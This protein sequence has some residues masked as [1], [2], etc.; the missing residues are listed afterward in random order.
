MVLQ[1]TLRDMIQRKRMVYYLTI[2]VA[3]VT[4]GYGKRVRGFC[5]C[6]QEP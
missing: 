3:R 5:T 4:A 2:T 1:I 6:S